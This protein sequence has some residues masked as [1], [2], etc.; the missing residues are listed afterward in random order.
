MTRYAFFDLDYTLTHKDTGT[1]FLLYNLKRRPSLFFRMIAGV[2]LVPLWK[3][4]LLPLWRLK[5]FFFGFLKEM[6]EKE[7]LRLSQEF[8]DIIWE[9]VIKPEGITELKRLRAEGYVPVLI[10]ASPHF[11]VAFFAEKLGIEHFA[12]TRYE[13]IGGF[14]S[15]KMDGPDCRGQEKVQRIAELVD[16]RS[17]DRMNSVAYSDSDADLPLLM[18][19]GKAFKVARREWRLKLRE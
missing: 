7:L 18:L 12:G 4:K 17:Y 15:G 9:K 3:L 14:V 2:V 11:Y 5:Q 19:A 8:V 10:S 13:I 1:L 16:L 6:A